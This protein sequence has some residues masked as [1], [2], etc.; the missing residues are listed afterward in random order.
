MARR[1][2]SRGFVA[3]PFD[4][5]VALGALA[6]DGIGGNTIVTFG[7]DL[8]VI[9][10]DHVFTLRDGTDGEVPIEVGFAHGDLSVAEID[11]Y[12][13]AELTD[14]DDIIVKERARRPVRRSGSFG[15][16]QGEQSLNHGQID[17]TKFKQSIGDGHGLTVW[18]SNRTGAT[19]TTGANIEC[20]GTIYGRWQR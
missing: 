9:S 4:Q 10:I 14:P 13:V 11:E 3:I 20:Q 16:D 12:L 7:E 19:L 8:F 5:I 1:R 17:R 6:N 18:A 2:R 15:G